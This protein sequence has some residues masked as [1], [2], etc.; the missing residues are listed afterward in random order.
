MLPSSDKPTNSLASSV[1]LTAFTSSQYS[2]LFL[3]N[4][5]PSR[6]LLLLRENRAVWSYSDRLK[7]SQMEAFENGPARFQTWCNPAAL[8]TSALAFITLDAAKLSLFWGLNVLGCQSVKLPNDFFSKISHL[9]HP[10]FSLPFLFS[11]APF[12]LFERDVRSVE[13]QVVQ[14]RPTSV[15]VNVFFYSLCL[16]STLLSVI[17]SDQQLSLPDENTKHGLN[18]PSRNSGS[19]Y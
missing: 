8:Q 12:S 17:A 18:R 11:S 19:K 4:S 16:F 10:V 15:K 6:C 5:S 9:Y 14:R 1:W 13:T 7:T 3:L 2:L